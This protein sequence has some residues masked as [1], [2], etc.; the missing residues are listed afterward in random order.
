MPETRTDNQGIRHIP[1]EFEDK[2]TLYS[3]IES[4]G[5]P[6]QH[7]TLEL[8][9]SKHPNFYN[10]EK[11]RAFTFK[12]SN[13]TKQTIGVY[14]KNLDSFRFPIVP[15]V[16]TTNELN[17]NMAD[18]AAS[19]MDGINLNGDHSINTS[20]TGEE[21]RASTNQR[22]STPP[23]TDCNVSFQGQATPPTTHGGGGSTAGASTLT[24]P[25]SILVGSRRGTGSPMLRQ[26]GTQFH[27]PPPPNI[28]DMST[29]TFPNLEPLFFVPYGPPMIPD[30]RS[31]PQVFAQPERNHGFTIHYVPISSVN[32]V[33][34]SLFEIRKDCDARQM[35]DY[36]CKIP[37]YNEAWFQ[38]YAERSL[39]LQEPA[40]CSS[41]DS[42]L[43]P[44]WFLREA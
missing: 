31:N 14:K 24:P 21:T 32:N 30:T 40:Q 34:V 18:K 25:R 7:V 12:L 5:V 10:G 9:N 17:A 2:L 13:I 26:T 36:T 27:P 6:R 1:L 33:R 41:I 3:D 11:S 42:T 39:L 29:T 38:P 16:H 35:G 8:L 19:A 44:S 22:T 15:G 43:S 23:R 37:Q 4:S 28:P 20:R